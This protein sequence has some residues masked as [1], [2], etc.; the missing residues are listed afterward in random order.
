MAVL[1]AR[2]VVVVARLLNLSQIA[3]KATDDF[4]CVHRRN[5]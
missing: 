3:Q 2:E 5:L 4:I 1:Q